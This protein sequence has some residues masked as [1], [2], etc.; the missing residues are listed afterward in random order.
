MDKPY[1]ET[2]LQS[3]FG[4]GRSAHVRSGGICQLCGCGAGPD[5]DF[6]LWRQ[7]TIEHL[8][9]EAQGG[10][11]PRI[12]AALEGSFAHLPESERMSLASRI[13]EANIVTAC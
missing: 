2:G 7:L 12:R 8:I 13:H 5:I 1:D 10:Y 4:Y 9:G 3:L 6:D 11:P